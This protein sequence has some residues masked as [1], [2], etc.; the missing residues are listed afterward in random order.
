MVWFPST[1]DPENIIRGLGIYV[2]E[3]SVVD[4]KKK[5][6]SR[7]TAEGMSSRKLPLEVSR[8]LSH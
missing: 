6:K 1:A 7:W 3:N 4:G 8:T 5:Q 2:R